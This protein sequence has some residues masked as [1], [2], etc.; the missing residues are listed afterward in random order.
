MNISNTQLF[1]FLMPGESG[2]ID[3]VA[4]FGTAGSAR[5]S[6]TDIAGGYGLVVLEW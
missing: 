1:S 4:G 5:G 2:D 3:Y 6:N